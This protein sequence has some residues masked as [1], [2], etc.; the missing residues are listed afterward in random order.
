M[1]FAGIYWYINIP[2][3]K[4]SINFLDVGQGDSILIISPDNKILLIDGGKDEKAIEE[5]QNKLNI[6]NRRI[7]YIIAT[8][9]DSDH[10]GG[11]DDIVD[12]YEVGKFMMPQTTKSTNV[13]K[14]LLTKIADD[15]IER[16]DITDNSDFSLGCCVTVDFLWPIMNSELI[17]QK[18]ENSLSAAFIIT[19]KNFQAYFDGDLPQNIEDYLVSKNP[20]DVDLIKV[21]HH[22]S[23][24]ATS[25]NFLNILKPE[26]AIISVGNNNAY[27][28]PDI[29]IINRLKY[30]KSMIL[31]TDEGG[32]IDIQTDGLTINY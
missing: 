17:D 15:N 19:Y 7:D 3:D 32:G 12:S 13:L 8:H 23:K 20:V 21:S 29:S 14:K 10:I 2:N 31:R 6:L 26:L 5:I 28:H 22:G 30:S 24:T 27:H 11:L 4:L 9:A 16:I 25:Q 1:I 18:N